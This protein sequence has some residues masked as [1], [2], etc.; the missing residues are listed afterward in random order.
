MQRFM[1]QVESVGGLAATRCSPAAAAPWGG[2][3]PSR[4]HAL[5]TSRSACSG[6]LIQGAALHV[7]TAPPAV[8]RVIMVH[9]ASVLYGPAGLP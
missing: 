8:L 6:K 5:P 2:T 4:G 3:S 7:P 1:E 9:T